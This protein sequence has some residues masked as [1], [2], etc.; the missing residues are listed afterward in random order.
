MEQRLL[1][2]AKIAEVNREAA[3]K[4][5]LWDFDDLTV[6]ECQTNALR[7]EIEKGIGKARALNARLIWVAGVKEVAEGIRNVGG[8]DCMIV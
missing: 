4:R 1:S 6:Y 7:E 5:N 8:G 3:R 2:D